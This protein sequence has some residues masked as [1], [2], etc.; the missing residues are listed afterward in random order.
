VYELLGITPRETV[1]FDKEE[2]PKNTDETE[3][4]N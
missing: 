3:E 4:N 2:L 1:R